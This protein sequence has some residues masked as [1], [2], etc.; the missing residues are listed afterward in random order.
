[1]AASEPPD[2]GFG[3]TPMAFPDLPAPSDGPQ[4]HPR[5]GLQAAPFSAPS[6][7]IHWIALAIGAL[8]IILAIAAFF[9]FF[10]G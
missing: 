2:E 3:V 5:P 9:A 6:G 1:M 4:F 8:L 10:S 7:R